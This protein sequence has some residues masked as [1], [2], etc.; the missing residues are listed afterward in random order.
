MTNNFIFQSAKIDKIKV[1]ICMEETIN[2][3]SSDNEMQQY[4]N[5][6]LYTY[7]NK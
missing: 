5:V 4:C 1:A 2:F 6:K 3:K 7:L